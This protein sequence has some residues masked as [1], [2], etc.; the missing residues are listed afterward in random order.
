MVFTLSALRIVIELR[1][2]RPRLAKD[3]RKSKRVV[4]TIAL[5]FS[6]SPVWEKE[7]L[8]PSMAHSTADAFDTVCRLDRYG[9]L[10]EVP[11]SKK[12]KVAAGLL[13]DKLHEQDFAGPISLRASRVL[14]PTSHY[15]L[16]TSCSHMK[17]VSRVSHR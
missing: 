5:L 13:L 4:D 11:H 3:L 17:L 15:Q 8:A 9:T 1:H 2:G 12:Q 7:F 16:R 6:L 14:V 10:D